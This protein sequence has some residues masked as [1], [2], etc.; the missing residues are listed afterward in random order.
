MS[1]VSIFTSHLSPT[2]WARTCVEFGSPGS[3]SP[4][5]GAITLPASFAGSLELFTNLNSWLA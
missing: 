5:P 2:S 1:E 3:A 4:S